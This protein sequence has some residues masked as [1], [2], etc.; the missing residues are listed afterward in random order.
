MGAVGLAV[1]D[2][3]SAAFWQDITVKASKTANESDN[4]LSMW[5]IQVLREYYFDARK[6][7][8]DKTLI[9]NYL[10]HFVVY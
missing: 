7:F 3:T 10:V 5:L 8:V 9:F 6:E 1:L 2:C 4:L